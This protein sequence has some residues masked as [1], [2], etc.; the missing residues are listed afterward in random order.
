MVK[1]AF[2]EDFQVD[3]AVSCQVFPAVACRDGFFCAGFL[4][5]LEEKQV[6]QFGDVLMVGDA[7]IPED[8]AEVPEPGND[9][10]IVHAAS[11]SS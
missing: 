10:L 4:S 7:I 3:A 5:H 6:C 11:L 9:F 2:V 8:I 1:Q